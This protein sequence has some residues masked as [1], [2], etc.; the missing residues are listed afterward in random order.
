[1]ANTTCP[2]TRSYEMRGLREPGAARRDCARPGSVDYF[3]SVTVQQIYQQNIYQAS[4]RQR[5][6]RR[7]RHGRRGRVQLQRDGRQARVLQRRADVDRRRRRAA[8]RRSAA[9]PRSCSA[10]P[11]ISPR[12][13]ITS[14]CSTGTQA[15][16]VI[17]ND[18]GLWRTTSSRRCACP[19]ASCRSSPSTRRPW[20]DTYWTES[21]TR[22]ACRHPLAVTARS[23]SISIRTSSGPVFNA[24]LQHAR[25]RLRREVQARHRAERHDPADDVD[26]QPG[27][28]VRFGRDRLRRRRHDPC[29]LRAVQPSLR[30]GQRVVGRGRGTGRRAPA[31]DPDRHHRQTYYSDDEASQFDR[32][33]NTSF[34]GRPPSN[35]SPVA[36]GVRGEPDRTVACRSSGPSPTRSSA[37]SR[38]SRNRHRGG[39]RVA[40]GGGRLQPAPAD[41]RRP[42]PRPLPPRQLP[43]R[44]A[45][46]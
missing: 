10:P 15:D 24:D 22:A 19:S 18:N 41:D 38:A 42:Q 31:R 7:E 13:A 43:Q 4:R 2:A 9:G 8:R 39:Q 45:S 1:M 36:I 34:R 30:E 27:S 6:L 37:S 5:V 25:Q 35:F 32:Q 44:L 26:R 29:H 28:I 20:H 16:D 46:T 33:N 23:T 12:T 21:L 3:S 17:T 11:S 40:H 14:T